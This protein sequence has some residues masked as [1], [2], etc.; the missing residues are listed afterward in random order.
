MRGH[1][2]EHG[3]AGC[4]GDDAEVAGDEKDCAAVGSLEDAQFRYFLEKV[5]ELAAAWDE[6][7]WANTVFPLSA[8]RLQLVGMSS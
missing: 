7:A 6:S 8:I 2:T 5:A 3:A 4:L 1:H